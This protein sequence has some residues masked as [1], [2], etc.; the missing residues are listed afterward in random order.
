MSEAQARDLHR[1]LDG[2]VDEYETEAAGY[3][4]AIWAY[5]RVL[6]IKSARIWRDSIAHRQTVRS[7]FRIRGSP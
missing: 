2:I 5:L 7:G 6:L 3:E 4:D 1:V